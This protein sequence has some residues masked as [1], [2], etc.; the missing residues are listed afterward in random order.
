ML[1]GA[2]FWKGGEFGGV[3]GVVV[4]TGSFWEGEW[5]S[6]PFSCLTPAPAEETE[7][8]YRE[9]LEKPGNQKCWTAP[10]NLSNDVCGKKEEEGN[11]A[12]AARELGGQLGVAGKQE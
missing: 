1:G 7:E 4:L 2:S 3:G 11:Q 12:D 6:Y 9:K 8:V 10:Q 5:I